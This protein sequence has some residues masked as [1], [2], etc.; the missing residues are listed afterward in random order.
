MATIPVSQ[1]THAGHTPA[2]Q[3]GLGRCLPI[4]KLLAYGYSEF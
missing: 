2:F 4:Q 1:G 3:R